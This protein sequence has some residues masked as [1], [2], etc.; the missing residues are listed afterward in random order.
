MYV[1]L[2]EELG[3]TG[4]GRELAGL[5]LL[6]SGSA[7][8]SPETFAAFAELTGHR[9]LERYGMTET[10]MLLSNPAAAAAGER[11]PGTVGTALPGVSMRIVDAGKNDVASGAEGELLVAG[12]NV[13]DGYWRAPEKTAT[14]FSTD[15]A[16]RRWFHTGDLA[17][18]DPEHGHVTL[19]GRR[20]ELIL[21]GGYNVY[22]REIEEVLESFPGIREAAVVGR[23]HPEFGE[24]PV[25][26]LVVDSERPPRAEEILAHCKTELAGFKQ[27]RAFHVLDALPRNALGKVQKHL[28][29]RD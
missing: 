9:I 5:R 13:F 18:R 28:L 10:G 1:R 20:T 23:P 21:C 6:C 27:P 25:A 19:L 14:S 17:R 29:P 24:S 7:P 11:R 12:S 3:R 15:A 26:F 4:R 16:G 22:P 2:V 8:L